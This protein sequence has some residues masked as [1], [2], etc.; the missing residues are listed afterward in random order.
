[1]KIRYVLRNINGNGITGYWT[2]R[3]IKVPTYEC[4]PRYSWTWHTCVIAL[5]PQTLQWPG[6]N[7]SHPIFQR[8]NQG[9]RKVNFPGE[10]ALAPASAWATNLLLIAVLIVYF[11]GCRKTTASGWNRV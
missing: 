5:N 4:P 9:S 7:Y 3:M 11:C 8:G 1:M 6:A 2:W 10:A